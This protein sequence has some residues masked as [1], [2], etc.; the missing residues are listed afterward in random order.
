MIEAD[1]AGLVSR[2]HL[3]SGW[4]AYKCSIVLLKVSSNPGQHDTNLSKRSSNINPPPAHYSIASSFEFHRLCKD[5]I[6]S[7]LAGV[8]DALFDVGS[9][10]AR[11]SGAVCSSS[12]QHSQS[13]LECKPQGRNITTR[14]SQASQRQ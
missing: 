13:D 14:P 1:D 6:N 4:D 11:P 8:Q 7:N 3:V 12:G 5:P 9:N 10:A 2:W